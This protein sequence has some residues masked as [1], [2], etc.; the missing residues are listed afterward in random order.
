MKKSVLLV[1]QSSGYL[2][3]DIV[4]AYVQSGKYDKVELFAGQINIRPSVPDPSV[5]VI[6][7]I[8]YNK[9]NT[10]KR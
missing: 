9:D 3:I 6:K 10:L 1:N 4:N 8:K 2:M 7:T 5:R